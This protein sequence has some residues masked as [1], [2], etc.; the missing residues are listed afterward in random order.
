LAFHHRQD[1]L[2]RQEDA[3]QVVV[4]LRI[5]GIFAHFNRSAVGR[6]ADIVDQNV[7]ATEMIEAGFHHRFDGCRVGNVTLMGDN[8]AAHRLHA[9]DGFPDGLEIAVDRE[10]P[11]AFLG[12]TNGDSAP[13]APAGADAAC[14]GHD[15]NPIMQT[16]GHD[17]SPVR[18]RA[19]AKR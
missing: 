12:E 8:R 16:A 6:A 4:D 9:I 3:L 10:N 13:V 5:P 15:C 17:G 1:V 2:Q 7:D 18:R 19:G 11:G 14:A